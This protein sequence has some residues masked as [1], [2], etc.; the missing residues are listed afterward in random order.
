MELRHGADVELGLALVHVGELL[1]AHLD[2]LFVDL[3][4]VLPAERLEALAGLE[5]PPQRAHGLAVVLRI[6]DGCGEGHGLGEVLPRKHQ[7]V[8]STH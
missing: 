3:V 7:V 1:L 5:Q 6:P 4:L 2:E 8:A